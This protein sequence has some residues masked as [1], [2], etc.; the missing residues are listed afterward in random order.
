[1]NTVPKKVSLAQRLRRETTRTPA[2]ITPRLKMGSW[3]CAA[4]LIYL[5]FIL[6]GVAH[7]AAPAAETDGPGLAQTNER[8]ASHLQPGAGF[9]KEP[10]YNPGTH[11]GLSG[12]AGGFVSVSKDMERSRA[13]TSRLLSGPASLP[14]SFMLD[15]KAV[16]GIPSGWGPVSN[17]RR[18]DANL[19]ETTFEK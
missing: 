19:I 15:G 12:I 16:T 9:T 4:N 10:E 18:I 6:A 14:L 5:A 17:R 1:M 8:A 2:W 13:L 3:T 7:L 11:G